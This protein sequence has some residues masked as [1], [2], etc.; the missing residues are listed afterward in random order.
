[1]LRA[2]SV[3]DGRVQWQF[4]TVTEFSAVNGIPGKGGSMGA[5]A[6]VVAGKRLFVPSGY[7]GVKNGLRGNV[8]LMFAP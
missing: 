4:D 5:A 7:V 3:R 2:L 6:P 1:M 8:L